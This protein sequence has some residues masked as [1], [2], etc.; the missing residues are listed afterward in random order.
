MKH[1]LFFFLLIPILALS[2]VPQ[3]VGYQGAAT[4]AAGF[5]L[6]NQSISIRASIISGTTAGT[7]EWQE[8]H[9]TS[10][11]TFGLFNLTIGQG[12]S[13]G[14]GA[15]TS[16]A[17][18]TWGS[19]NHFLKIEMDI[20]GGTNYSH[21]GTNQMMSV[22]YALY[23]EKV[24]LD[25]DSL[26]LLVYDSVMSLL[27]NDSL[28]LNNF[29]ISNNYSFGDYETPTIDLNFFNNPL[30]TLEFY[31]DTSQCNED[32]FLII[33]IQGVSLPGTQYL[34]VIVLDSSLSNA[35]TCNYHRGGTSGYFQEFLNIPIKKGNF[36]FI[37]RSN[38]L[39]P[40][41]KWLPI[42]NDNNNQT[43]TNSIVNKIIFTIDGF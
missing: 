34:D 29:N 39:V 25:F 2:Q 11:D 24:N 37:N 6:I 14:N 33:Q 41:I 19:A 20:N 32:G 22:P 1:F 40:T 42:I 10:T 12:T 28:L 17:D 13:T 38:I 18:I 36:Y 9:N 30:N 8:T 27:P 3:G 23:A 7:I 35:I 26:A 15:Q 31:S 16:F 43:Q 4:D 5:E 21:M